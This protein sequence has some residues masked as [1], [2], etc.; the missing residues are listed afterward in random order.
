MG[1]FGEVTDPGS[2]S[3]SRERHRILAAILHFAEEA[4]K[5]PKKLPGQSLRAIM[6]TSNI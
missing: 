6:H 4:E 3:S 2:G 5:H 1:K